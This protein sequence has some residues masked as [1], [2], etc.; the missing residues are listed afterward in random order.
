MLPSNIKEYYYYYRHIQAPNT[1]ERIV[2]KL[3]LDQRVFGFYLNIALLY[4]SFYWHQLST[5]PYV[6]IIGRKK[7]ISKKNKKMNTSHLCL[8]VR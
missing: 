1:E 4:E 6:L 7:F 8:F 5:Q 2:H 3:A